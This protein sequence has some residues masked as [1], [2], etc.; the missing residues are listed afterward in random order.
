MLINPKTIGRRNLTFIG[1]NAIDIVLYTSRL[2]SFNYKILVIDLSSN[3]SILSIVS[4]DG[5]METHNIR[6]AQYDSARHELDSSYDL[7]IAYSD[8]AENIPLELLCGEIY[9]ITATGRNYLKGMQKEIFHLSSKVEK[10]FVVCRGN[11][12]T[13]RIKK[14][15][16][17]AGL[18]PLIKN[19]IVFLC[20]KEDDSAAL[21]K[22]EYNST[23]SYENLSKDILHFLSFILGNANQSIDFNIAPETTRFRWV[24]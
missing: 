23:F 4:P 9:L 18:A 24:M 2:C 10:V 3:E 7:V 20:D 15:E 8:K 6:Y 17:L 19:Q 22:M 1:E 14:K 13:E 11:S 5:Y 16:F 21:Y 12:S